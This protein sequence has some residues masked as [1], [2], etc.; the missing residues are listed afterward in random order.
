LVRG[1][2]AG[3]REEGVA[4]APSSRVQGGGG[5][6]GTKILSIKNLIFCINQFLKY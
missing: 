2:V 3:G 4:A 6:M 5:K 1:G